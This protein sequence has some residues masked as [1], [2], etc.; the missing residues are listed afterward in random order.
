MARI[1]FNQLPKGMYEKVFAVEQYIESSGLDMRL[2]ELMRYRISQINHCLYC[3]DMHFKIA[4]KYG[5]TDLRLYSVSGWEEAPY[6]SEKERAVL[7]FA[8]KLTQLNSTAVSDEDF[9]TLSK[10]FTQDEVAHLT[11]AVAQINTWNRLMDA[12]RF[13][14][15]KFE[16]A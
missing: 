13:E 12:F 2:L 11:L 10:H 5:E 7:S 6:Y 14:P 15:G 8:E 16:V 3:L 1:E 9:S 4:K